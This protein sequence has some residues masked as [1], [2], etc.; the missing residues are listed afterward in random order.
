M[1]LLH[2]VQE[3]RPGG[4]ERVVIALSRGAEAAGHVVAVA[5]APGALDD[6]LAAPRYE[7]PLLNRRAWRL[8][9]AGA[10]LNGAVRRFDPDLLHVHNLEWRL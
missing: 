8:P 7:L 2:V 4:A 1:R 5:A 6:E 10:R 3:L 9:A